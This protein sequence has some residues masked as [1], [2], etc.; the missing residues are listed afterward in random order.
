[1]QVAVIAN[2]TNPATAAGMKETEA[3]AVVLG[4]RLRLHTVRDEAEIERAFAAMAAERAE[5][6]V[7]LQ[8]PTLSQH[9]ERVVTLAAR[10][11]IPTI[12]PQVEWANAGGLVAYAASSVELFRRAAGQVDRILR[13]AKPGDLPV[14][15]PTKFEM[16][17]NMKTAKRLGLA[18]PQGLL[19]RADRIIE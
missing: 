10:Y 7:V 1:M 16:I 2:P 19:L 4:L 15:Q 17:V 13:G 12:Y 11:R 18:I 8:D 5:A 6:L 9:R 14:E 3:A